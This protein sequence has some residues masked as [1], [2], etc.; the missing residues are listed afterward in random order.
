V[1]GTDGPHSCLPAGTALLLELEEMV[2]AGLTPLDAIAAATV[3][4][5]RAVG[6]DSLG[7]VESGK[8]ADVILVDGDP[9]VDI[10]ALRRVKAVVSRGRLFERAALDSLTQSARLFAR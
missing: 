8:V 9:S 4:A 6:A 3:G 5:A 10:T 1:A 7:T 2:A